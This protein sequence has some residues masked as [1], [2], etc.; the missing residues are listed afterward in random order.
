MTKF[1]R[2]GFSL[3]A[4]LVITE[5]YVAPCFRASVRTK[6]SPTSTT[7]K[8]IQ[9]TNSIPTNTSAG[10]INP[11]NCGTQPL[12]KKSSLKIVGGTQAPTGY[13]G[14]QVVIYYDGFFTCGGSLINSQWILTAAH[15]VSGKLSNP[16]KFTLGLGVSD[17]SVPDNW[18]VFKNGVKIIMHENYSPETMEN[19]I[20]LIKLDSPVEYSDYIVPVCIPVDSSSYAN[21]EAIATGF[22]LTSENG[23]TS[24]YLLQVNL[25]WLTDEICEKKANTG[26]ANFKNVCI[27]AGETGGNKDTCQGDSGGPLVVL[28][29]SKYM[30][31]G[32]T[33]WGEG[34]MNGGVYARVSYYY[35]WINRYLN[36]FSD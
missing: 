34:C 2:L 27:C 9:T 15:C 35:S 8:P 1:I 16:S 22:G 33:S 31:G 10:W 20:A 17:R 32:I 7:T 30:L 18:S 14:W 24:R 28:E 13:W 36:A 19:D 12:E 5:N 11:I 6:K 21:L 3:I 29:N 25:K 23:Q 26:S 4:I